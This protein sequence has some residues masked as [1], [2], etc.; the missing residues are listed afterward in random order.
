[1]SPQQLRDAIEAVPPGSLI[2]YYRGECLAKGPGASVGRAAH[3]LS[4]AGVVELTRRRISGPFPADDPRRGVFEYI[5]IKRREPRPPKKVW[6]G[7]GGEA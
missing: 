2:S 4:L 1:M 3:E 7:A 6:Q 5:A